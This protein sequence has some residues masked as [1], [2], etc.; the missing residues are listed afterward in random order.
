MGRLYLIRHGQASFGAENYDSLSDLGRQQAK[1]L[2]EN[3]ARHGLV[4][5]AI[6]QGTLQRQ[7]QTASGIID[8]ISKNK[9]H[10]PQIITLE[11]LDEYDALTVWNTHL[12]G[13]IKENPLMQR[14]LDDVKTDSKAFQRLFEQVTH[15]WVSGEYDRDGSPRW[16]DFKLRVE[17][18]LRTIIDSHGPGSE[19]AVVTSAGTISVVMQHALGL[20]DTKTLELS[21]QILNSSVTRIRYNGDRITLSG[22][23]DISHLEAT[24]NMD[25]LTYR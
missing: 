23:N 6:Y 5:N 21:W 12:A 25:L 10:L 8:C 14:N 4:F 11:A 1:I 16:Q 22:F 17:K 18:G 24:G 2:G 9:S 15:R 7:T 20:S 3:L 13:V 19:V